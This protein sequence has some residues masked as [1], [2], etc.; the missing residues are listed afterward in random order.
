MASP[1]NQLLTLTLLISCMAVMMC[2]GYIPSLTPHVYTEGQEIP[3]FINKLTS[4]E[5]PAPYLFNSLPVCKPNTQP[6]NDN[7]SYKQP[8]PRNIGQELLGEEMQRTLYKFNFLKN[9]W[10]AVLNAMPD[11][12]CSKDNRLDQSQLDQFIHLIRNSY[13]ANMIL[14]SL[15]VRPLSNPHYLGTRLGNNYDDQDYLYNHFDFTVTY[16]P[17][18]TR[19]END[20]YEIV[21][22]EVN[23]VSKAYQSQEYNPNTPNICPFGDR[24]GLPIS[25]R[26]LVGDNPFVLWTYSVRY[27]LNESMSWSDRWK[28]PEDRLEDILSLITA[29]STGAWLGLAIG[30]SINMWR[31]WRRFNAVVETEESTRWKL[32]RGDVFRAPPLQYQMILPIL[33]GCGIQVMCVV[34]LSLFLGAIGFFSPVN[35]GYIPMAIIA[36]FTVTSMF[37]GYFSTRNYMLFKGRDIKKNALLAALCPQ[38]VIFIIF[39]ISDICLKSLDSSAAISTGSMFTLIGL[40]LGMSVPLSFC[41]SYYASKMPVFVDTETNQFPREI[42]S[43]TPWYYNRWFTTLTMATTP[44]SMIASTYNGI[45]KTSWSALHINNNANY[46]MAMFTMLCILSVV[47]LSTSH[48]IALG[49]L[50]YEN[51]HWWWRSFETMGFSGFYLFIITLFLVCNWGGASSASAIFI[52]SCYSLMFS[53]CLSVMAGSVAYYFSLHFVRRIY[54]TIHIN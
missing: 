27:Q 52:Y 18:N 36:L 38:G 1:I 15:P 24:A 35:Y 10:C 30:G 13:H 43:G 11:A 49:L 20:T 54:S 7:S 12:Q 21:G 5:S 32:I 9:V 25:N 45:L 46:T 39:V 22:F 34:L 48:F 41:G 29:L 28:A 2:H 4:I 42:P 31:L 19:M 8:P 51:Y 23:P 26:T 16:R 3:M 47:G 44:V 6:R 37:S 14:D 40:W 50:R 33:I 17:T 53:L